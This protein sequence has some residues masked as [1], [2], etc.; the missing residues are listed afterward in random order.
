M[1]ETVQRINKLFKGVE[2][3][4]IYLFGASISGEK[5]FTLLYNY[6]INV[7]NF[8]DNDEKKWGNKFCGKTIINVNKLCEKYTDKDI[9]IISSNKHNIISEQLKEQSIY[10]FIVFEEQFINYIYMYDE[11]K[12][13][14]NKSPWKRSLDWLLNSIIPNSG[15]KVHN[16]SELPYP[17]V[18][19]YIIPT[20]YKY[21]YIEEA[22][23]LAKWLISIQNNDGGFTG[24]GE[25]KEYIFD[26]AQIL[27]GFLVFKDD[28][29]IREPIKQAI[30]KVTHYLY[31]NIL[32]NGENGYISQ[33]ESDTIIPETILLYTLKPF[34][35]A[36]KYLNEIK[37]LDV[38]ENLMNYYL[39]HKNLLQKSTLTHFLSYEIEALIELNKQEYVLDI[40]KY[41]ENKQEKNNYISAMEG[42][43]WVCTPG[44][45]QLA[46]C[47]YKCGNSSAANKAIL[48]LE[49]L[50][51]NSGA[52]FGSYGDGAEYFPNVEISWVIKYYLDANFLR[53][54]KWFDDNS[55]D[56]PSSITESDAEFAFI[57]KHVKDN[58]KIAEIGCG[59]GRFLKLLKG[60]HENLDLTGVDISKEMLSALSSDVEGIWAPMEHLPL[61]SDTY[62]MVFS[63]EAIEHSIN[64][65][66]SIQEMARVLKPEGIL[67]IIDK[68]LQYW[69]RLKC[70]SWESWMDKEYLKESIKK[71]CDNVFYETIFLDPMN[72]N[73]ELMIAW[74]GTKYIKA[75]GNV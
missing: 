16:L 46:V 26:S 41:M 1:I 53:I 23:E 34:K 37:Y 65:K 32:N 24:A 40:L 22:R 42:C 50:Q 5:C 68:N 29:I 64:I 71:Y 10:N 44:I 2:A 67:C 20:L 25:M 7:E 47:W 17:E 18:T 12:V 36:A 74:V 66:R 39:N 62:D 13:N 6:N 33:Y 30:R 45:A 49:E 75:K 31:N 63:V 51:L 43:N 58:M 70:P 21:G 55:D 56:F 60:K 52:F 35:E 19:G 15:V 28:E 38:I 72:T 54:E 3:G 73:D 8:I 57:D 27:R 4:N 11:I 9:I 59:K 48:Y 61:K 14:I 69:G